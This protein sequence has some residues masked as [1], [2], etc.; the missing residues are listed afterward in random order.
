MGSKKRLYRVVF[1]NQGKV[2]EIYARRV[3]Q[4]DLYGF[5]GVE[6][7]LFG[8]KSAVVIDPSEERLK[9]EFDGVSRTHIPMHAIVRIDEVE[10]QGAAKIVPLSGKAE[11]IIPFPGPLGAP[12]GKKGGKD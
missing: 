8:E 2:Y 11:D 4:G 9:S 10:R 12:T 5:V 1:V 7:I 6:D 3:N